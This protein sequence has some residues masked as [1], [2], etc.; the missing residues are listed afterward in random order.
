M[1]ED[2]YCSNCRAELP[3][4]A[5]ECPACGIYAG[6][7]FD[8]V[9]PRERAARRRRV[10]V[11]AVVL[12]AVIA[13]VIAVRF[14]D[15]DSPPWRDANTVEAPSTR[16]VGDRPGVTRRAEGSTL[17]EAEAMRI[18][19]RHLVAAD[20]GPAND[21]IALMSNGYSDRAWVITAY[22]RCDNTRL[23]RWKVD[24]RTGDVSR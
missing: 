22:N 13:V 20:G 1:P 3:R 5:A 6:D 9:L 12:L 14:I 17:T 10:I 15:F 4:R 21:C 16:V 19:R 23:G 7:V 8:G 11:L 2:R 18:V 24:G